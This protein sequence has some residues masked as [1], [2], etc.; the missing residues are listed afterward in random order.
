MYHVL[1]F[2][3]WLTNNRRH[4]DS[5][6][7]QSRSDVTWYLTSIL[8]TQLKD[9]WSLKRDSTL[10]GNKNSKLT[11]MTWCTVPHDALRQMMYSYHTANHGSPTNPTNTVNKYSKIPVEYVDK[12]CSLLWWSSCFS[13]TSLEFKIKKKKKKKKEIYNS[14]LF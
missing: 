13:A 4:A 14:M 2:T 3:V 7:L 8:Q 5:N 10:S 6:I 9:T 1:L 11:L 12:I